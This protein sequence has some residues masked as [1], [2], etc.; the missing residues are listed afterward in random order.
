MESEEMD[1]KMHVLHVVSF[2]TERMGGRVARGGAAQLF[3]YLPQLWAHATAAAHNMLRAAALAALVHLLKVL[4]LHLLAAVLPWY[5]FFY[6]KS[7]WIP[8]VLQCPSDSKL[9]RTLTDYNH[10]HLP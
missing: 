9:C 8:F 6:H 1:T 5:L 2:V 4:I 10:T 3:A 7:S